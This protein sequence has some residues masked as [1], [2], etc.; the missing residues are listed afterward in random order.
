MVSLFRLQ[1]ISLICQPI[2][3]NRAKF[4][5]NHNDLVMDIFSQPHKVDR[6]LRRKRVDYTD[7]RG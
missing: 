3:I 2:L 1:F 4:T 7:Q 6:Y 5:Q